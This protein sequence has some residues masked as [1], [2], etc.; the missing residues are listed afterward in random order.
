[1]LSEKE[2]LKIDRAIFKSQLAKQ[3]NPWAICTAQV[4]RENKEKYES[5]VMHVK[6]KLGLHKS[7]DEAVKDEIKTAYSNGITEIDALVN[8]AQNHGYSRGEASQLVNLALKKGVDV[9]FAGEVP[10]TLLAEQD[11]ESTTKSVFK[12]FKDFWKSIFDKSHTDSKLPAMIEDEKNGVKEYAEAAAETSEEQKVSTF[13]SMASDEL[14]H[15]QMLE[16]MKKMEKMMD[17]EA[18][19]MVREGRIEE[20]IRRLVAEEGWERSEALSYIASIRRSI[21]SKKLKSIA[22]SISDKEAGA[23]E[24]IAEEKEERA[25]I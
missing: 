8:I 20:L 23:K 2:C 22:K 7:S 18:E 11:L 4:G 14:R 24:Q 15:Q 21:T 19:N 16:G 1:M 25:K 3:S 12:S 5:C 17:S 9:N 6:E 10:N 13:L